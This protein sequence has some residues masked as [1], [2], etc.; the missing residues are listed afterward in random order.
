MI[1]YWLDVMLC[2]LVVLGRLIQAIVIAILLQYTFN[3]FLNINLFK[4]FWKLSD[5]LDKKI[6]KI[7]G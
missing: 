5:K 6:I 4:S 2:S 7:F 1:S 3:K